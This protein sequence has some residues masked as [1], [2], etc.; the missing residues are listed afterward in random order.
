M[1]LSALFQKT[2]SIPYSNAGVSASYALHRVQ[3][4]LYL[5]FESSE[6]VND[7][8]RNLDFPAKAHKRM[9]RSAWYAHRGFLDTWK[10]L[11]ATVADAISDKGIR[12]IVISGYS[13]GAALA[14][15]CHEYVWV[16]RPDLRSHTEGYGFGCPRVL[17]GPMRKAVK[18]R[19]ARFTVVRN[20]DDLVTHLPPAFLG[21]R[22]AGKLLEIG[23]RGKYSPVEAHYA[24]HYLTELTAYDTAHRASPRQTIDPK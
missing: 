22:Q 14:L 21:Y 9:G 19:W 18:A 11:E 8:K 17:W 3:E 12:K 23:E 10:E 24:Q 15:L 16:E 4:T 2:V 1:R 5:F 20:V 6:G 13:H 7:W